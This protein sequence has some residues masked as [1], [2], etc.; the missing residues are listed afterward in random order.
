MTPAIQSIARA[1]KRRLTLQEACSE[2]EKSRKKKCTRSEKRHK[3]GWVDID[4]DSCSWRVKNIDTPTAGARL[5]NVKQT[6]SL[7][8]VFFLFYLLQF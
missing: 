7:S 1:P 6:A 4:P 3:E 5:A 8:D 2:F